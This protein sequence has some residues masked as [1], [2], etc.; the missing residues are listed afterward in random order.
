MPRESGL[1][2]VDH[3]VADEACGLPPLG[4][5]VR[6]DEHADAGVARLVEM[7]RHLGQGGARVGSTRGGH[8]ESFHARGAQPPPG[9]IKRCMICANASC[10]FVSMTTRTAWLLESEPSATPSLASA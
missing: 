2:D 3:D 10:S 9:S 1:G 7:H 6:L 8:R 5:G 4:A